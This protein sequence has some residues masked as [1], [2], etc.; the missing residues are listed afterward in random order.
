MESNQGITQVEK[1]VVLEVK[2]LETGY[3]KWKGLGR[4]IYEGGGGGGGFWSVG[5]N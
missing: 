5:V 1:V 4:G 2:C 3:Y